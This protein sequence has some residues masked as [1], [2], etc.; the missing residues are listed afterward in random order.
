MMRIN[1]LNKE[2]ILTKEDRKKPLTHQ[3]EWCTFKTNIDLSKGIT[4]TSHSQAVSYDGYSNDL[5]SFITWWTQTVLPDLNGF[6][7]FG[8]V[9][10]TVK[11][12]LER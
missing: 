11:F 1:I 12:W 3:C 2:G 6:S 9:K 10:F 4:V 5:S 7:G 8:N